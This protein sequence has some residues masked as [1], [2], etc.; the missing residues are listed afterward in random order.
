MK[1]MIF[2]REEKQNNYPILKLK[3]LMTYII[4]YFIQGSTSYLNITLVRMELNLS[5]KV[6]NFNFINEKNI[7][8]GE[9][10]LK[11]VN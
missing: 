11:M 5:S 4:I 3:T 10:L 9:T 6:A 8:G 2:F 7:V 1:L